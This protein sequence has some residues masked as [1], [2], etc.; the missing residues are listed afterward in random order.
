MSELEKLVKEWR[1]AQ[2]AID[3][4]PPRERATN[5]APLERMMAAHSALCKY[6]DEH[7]K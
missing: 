4:M 2:H 3:A 6:A 5:A 1:D 7:L